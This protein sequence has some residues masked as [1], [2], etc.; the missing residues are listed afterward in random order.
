M[1]GTVLRKISFKWAPAAAGL[2]L[3]AA[4]PAQPLAAPA[5][6][7]A[8]W[9]ALGKLPD[10][11]GVWVPDTV[12]Q[13]R[14]ETENTPPWTPKVGAEM[15]KLVQDE[16]DGHPFFVLSNCQPYGMPALMLM[17]HN[18]MEILYTPGRVTILGESDGNRQ[19]RIYTDGRGHGDD[20]DITAHGHS[21]GHWDKDVLVVDTVAI[22]P[23]SFLA[24]SEGVAVPSDGDMRVQERIH[25]TAKDT[26][27]DDMVITD[28]KVLTKPWQTTRLWHR[29]RGQQY[30]IVEGECVQGSFDAVK[31]K[32]GHDIY[33]PAKLSSDGS[34]VPRAQ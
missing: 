19:R 31:D 30:E 12:D 14:Q 5:P 1:E 28:P 16:M 11:S 15:A 24:I 27:A 26:L 10:F 7:P 34:T 17:T 2:A 32:N 25:L 3:I 18:S 13:K 4:V 29:L 6:T 33:V 20:P 8:D 21:I 9:A 23:Q 22:A